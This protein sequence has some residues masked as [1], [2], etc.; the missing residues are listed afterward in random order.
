MKILAIVPARCGSKGFP[1]KNIA[2]VGGKTLLEL[3]VN[4]GLSC[5]IVDDVYISTDC[6]EYEQIAIKAGA[7]S[8]G[9]RPEYLATDTAKSINAIIDVLEKIDMMYDYVILLQPTSPLRRPDDIKNMI[10]KIIENDSDASVSVV[11]L[12][13]PHPYKLKS[14]DNEGY[15]TPFIDGAISEIPRQLLPKVYALNG[16]LYITK[17]SVILKEKTFLP[18]HTIPYIMDKLINIDTEEDFIFMETMLKSRKI[19]LFGVPN[20]NY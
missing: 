3:A 15:I 10:Q 4:V 6:V 13:E 17:A 1:H 2:K 12:D 14:I 18:K 19:K 11:Q 8:L 5:D 16:A 7:K 20:A 9:L